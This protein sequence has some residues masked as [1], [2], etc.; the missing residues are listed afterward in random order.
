VLDARTT[1][2]AVIVGN[3]ITANPSAGSAHGIWA[4]SANNITIAGNTI[5]TSAPGLKYAIIGNNFTVFAAGS[6]GNV[7]VGG[8]CFFLPG[9]P[10]GSVGF[11]TIN[12][13]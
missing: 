7:A 12:C 4:Q 1:T 11:S 8:T 3:T 5:T 2:N 13:P 10:A 9:P 6:T